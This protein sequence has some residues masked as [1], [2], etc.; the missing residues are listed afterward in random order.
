[1]VG[2]EINQQK[3]RYYLFNAPE[4]LTRFVLPQLR[5]SQEYIDDV[6]F[7]HGKF[8]SRRREWKVMKLFF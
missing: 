8:R 4:S 7:T 2:E 5:V 1:M 6:F 3:F